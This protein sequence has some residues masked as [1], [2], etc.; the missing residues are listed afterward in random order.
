MII[1][2]PFLPKKNQIPCERIS[3]QPPTLTDYHPLVI[4]QAKEKKDI[5][6]SELFSN[7]SVRQS[8]FGPPENKREGAKNKKKK[9]QVR[10]D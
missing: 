6:G 3:L 7:S 2:N 9:K 8:L 4:P 10:V 5:K 1:D